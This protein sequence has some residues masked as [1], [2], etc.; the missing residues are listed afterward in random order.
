MPGNAEYSRTYGAPAPQLRG[1][2]FMDT[3]RDVRASLEASSPKSSAC[4]SS[5]RG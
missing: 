2:F 3:V 5:F 1:E 4:A